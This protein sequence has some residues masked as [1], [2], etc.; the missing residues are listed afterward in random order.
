VVEPRV[1]N[2]VQELIDAMRLATESGD[3]G[4][5]LGILR[6]FA[7]TE[8]VVPIT[9]E[10]PPRPVVLQTER[11]LAAPAFTS[12]DALR[13]WAPEE[14]PYGIMLGQEL[15]RAAVQGGAV[16]VAVN[17]TG[18]FGGELFHED[19]VAIADSSALDLQS[20][21]GDVQLFTVREPDQLLFATC[22]EAPETLIAAV[23]ETAAAA[24]GVD[25]A[26]VLQAES[27]SGPHLALGVILTPGAAE[28]VALALGRAVA[29]TLPAGAPLDI[30]A[31][32]PQQ[33]TPASEPVYKRS[34]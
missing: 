21:D 13:E 31:L 32:S 34:L 22:R 23:R 30:L 14:R 7:T 28:S 12:V 4:D 1:L 19:L 18:P 20:F 29:A 24:S 5:R 9:N 25:A 27:P 26:Y 11:G 3:P 15:A 8:I 33:L 17:I 2:G 16:A 10:D 6:A